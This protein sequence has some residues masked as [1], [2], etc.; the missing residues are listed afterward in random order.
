MR[1][2]DD[3]RMKVISEVFKDNQKT[4]RSD[5]LKKACTAV[6][7]D[8]RMSVAVVKLWVDN[9]IRDQ[10]HCLAKTI[11]EDMLKEADEERIFTEEML[12]EISKEGQK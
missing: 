8:I 10:R 6:A 2:T 3:F 1:Y 9:Y 4:F 11:I 7:K 12:T 5:G